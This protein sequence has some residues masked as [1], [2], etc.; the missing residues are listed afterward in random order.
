MMPKVKSVMNAVVK[1]LGAEGFDTRDDVA[2]ISL[3]GAGMITRPELRLIC[4]MC[5]RITISIF[6]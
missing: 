2:K 4:S 5:W 6:I 3:V 1:E